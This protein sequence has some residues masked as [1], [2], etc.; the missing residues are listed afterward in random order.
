VAT[1]DMGQKEGGGCCAPFAGAGTPSGT[2][3][4][5]PRSTSVYKAASGYEMDPVLPRIACTE[6]SIT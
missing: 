1:I 2:I 4:P 6:L 3:W 5:G